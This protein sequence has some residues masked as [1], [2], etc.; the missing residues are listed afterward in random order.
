MTP[1][2]QA[3]A[4]LAIWQAAR[5][6][7]PEQRMKLIE[8]YHDAGRQDKEASLQGQHET[9]GTRPRSAQIK[10]TDNP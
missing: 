8:V 3:D 4:L 9:S 10:Q 2:Q 6:A 5:H 7:S 1:Q